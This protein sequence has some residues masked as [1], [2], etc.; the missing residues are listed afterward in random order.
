MLRSILIFIGIFAVLSLGYQ[1]SRGT[2]IETLII[3]QA[4]VKPGAALI[5][6]LQDQFTAKAEGH[7]IVSD[8]ARLSVLNGCEGTEMLFLII[9]AVFSFRCSARAKLIGL[10][11]GVLLVFVLNQMRIAALFFA[12]IHDPHWFDLIHGY[13]GP[14]LIVFVIALCYLY[15]TRWAQTLVV[16]QR[17]QDQR[18]QSL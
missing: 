3:D 12:L 6:T 7:R 18:G 14:T 4:T 13:V 10:V 8:K 1:Y 9:A 11:G 5:N 15:W 2:V 16:E 17:G